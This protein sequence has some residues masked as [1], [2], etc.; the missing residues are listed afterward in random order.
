[1][2]RVITTFDGTDLSREDFEDYLINGVGYDEAKILEMDDDEL[3]GFV[4]EMRA[5]YEMLQYIEN[6]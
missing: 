1:M 2:K 4:E 3:I 5:E 6:L